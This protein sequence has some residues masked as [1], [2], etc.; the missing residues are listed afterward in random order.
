MTDH[1]EL[2]TMIGTREMSGSEATR[3]RKSDMNFSESSSP[4][5]MFT[6]RMFAPPSICCLA[7][8]SAP[9]RSPSLI[10]FANFG[11]PV[12]LVR[13]PTTMKF[14]SGVTVS[15]SSPLRRR[16][17]STGCGTRGGSVATVS[18]MRRM[19]SNPVPQQPPT[20]FSQPFAAKS[21]RTSAI[22]VGV[23]S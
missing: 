15:G 19:C 23:S 13:S 22:I 18:A 2:S 8:R 5:S 1:F 4:S 3:L 16:C 12:T 7:T 10:S 9:S 21:R 17:G 14:D 11:E 20:M 6:S